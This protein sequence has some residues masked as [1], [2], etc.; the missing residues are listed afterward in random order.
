MKGADILMAAVAAV[1]STALD[2]PAQ[3]RGVQISAFSSS[4]GKMD[5][6]ERHPCEELQ[7]RPF[8]EDKFAPKFD[9]LR[10]IETLVTAH[11]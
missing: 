9:G 1:A 5:N 7:C 3:T 8:N 11:R 2:F 6:L 10:F 4:R